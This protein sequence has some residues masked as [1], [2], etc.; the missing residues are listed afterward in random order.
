M[1][2]PPPPGIREALR[3]AAGLLELPRLL[4][5]G[6]RLAA[7]P[8]GNGAPVLVLPGYG[9]TD[10]S[11]APLRAYL[12]WLGWSVHGWGLGRNGGDAH[13][14]RRRIVPIVE[15][16]AEA[17]GQ[18][19]RLV[20]WSLGG[21]LAREVARD[22]PD[23]AECVITLGSPVIGGPKYTAAAHAYRRR[24]HD[25]DAIEAAVAARCE[26]PLAVPV[27]AIYSRTDGVVLWQACLDE[28]SHG[29]EHVEVAT[30]HIGL[31][32]AAEV[33]EVIASRL[34]T[35]RGAPWDP[36]RSAP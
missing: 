31:G 18:R 22:L 24:G 9:T 36:S 10:A 27:T 20:G 3:E 13:E 1:E 6:R 5:H 21:Y 33:W 35:G 28:T 25:L 17:S 15:R 34:A 23:L 12:R 4:F 7:A 19:V 16:L 26:V 11:T 30:T 14:L 8:R 29:V 32:F 2:V